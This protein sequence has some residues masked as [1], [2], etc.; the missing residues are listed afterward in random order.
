MADNS[1]GGSGTYFL[2]EY[3]IPRDSNSIC[4]YDTRSLSDDSR[5]NNKMLKNWMTKGVRHGELVARFI[6]SHMLIFTSHFTNSLSG[7]WIIRD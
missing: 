5:E 2:R 6:Y 4:M 1:L 7:V 3:M